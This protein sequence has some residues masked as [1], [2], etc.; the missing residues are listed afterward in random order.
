MRQFVLKHNIGIHF[1]LLTVPYNLSVFAY[2]TMVLYLIISILPILLD[3]IDPL[4]ETRPH[5][6]IFEAEYGVDSD[7]YYWLITAHALIVAIATV[8]M[9]VA[10]ET[11]YV[12]MIV[13]ACALFEVVV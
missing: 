13:H 2:A 11:V 4:N 8:N 7:K 6:Y 1:L 9:L 5:D 10:F 12:L 3:F